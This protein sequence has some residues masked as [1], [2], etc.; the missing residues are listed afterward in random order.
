MPTP[1]P[2]EVLLLAALKDAGIDKIGDRLALIKAA[3][4]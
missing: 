1:L 2:A 4:A 3:N